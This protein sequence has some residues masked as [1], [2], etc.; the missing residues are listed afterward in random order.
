MKNS[1]SLIQ[2]YSIILL[3]LLLL[4][5]YSYYHYNY[6]PTSS[7]FL[8]VFNYS[9]QV[10]RVFASLANG[11]VA[12]FSQNKSLHSSNGCN[13]PSTE[14]NTGD[15]HFVPAP[16]TIKCRNEQY[17]QEADKWANPLILKLEEKGTPA[18]CMAFVGNHKLWCGCGNTIVV[19]DITA[20]SILHRFH[21][22]VRKTTLVNELVSNGCKVW[23]VG[24]DLSCVMEWDVKTYK[25]LH[26]FDCSKVDPTG[27]IVQ[28]DP[29]A[30]EDVIS[31]D[32]KEAK[33]S[34]KPVT[35]ELRQY[36]RTDPF[37]VNNEPT[38]TSSR[39]LF[40]TTRT[41]KSLQT[42]KKKRHLS[43]KAAMAKHSQKHLSPIPER[44]FQ[45]IQQ[46]SSRTTS[47]LIVDKTL[48]VGRGMGDIL[49]IDISKASTEHG[50]VLARLCMEKNEN[51][52]RRSQHK[53]QN[54]AGEYVVSSQWL[55]PLDVFQGRRVSGSGQLSLT[56]QLAHA[57]HF[58]HQAVTVWAAWS[59]AKILEFAK[60]C[61]TML[62]N[63]LSCNGTV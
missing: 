45:R 46:S 5:Y 11:T 9:I 54:V 22:F 17:Q 31:V 60:S 35:L 47:L 4:H 57:H 10:T 16:C 28:S 8:I 40:A 6:I 25:L 1:L 42:L 30:V 49:V 43:K 3:L 39:A 14:Q 12:I 7:L 33:K 15:A 48:W 44:S 27:R 18:K 62:Q 55:E 23:G 41:R 38:P 37:T 32:F 29:A 50:K 24:R 52:G 56:G 26:I 2:Y 34:S 53:L 63:E 59:K 13:D 19:V 21:V 36:S 58:T 51:Y 20:I 61:E